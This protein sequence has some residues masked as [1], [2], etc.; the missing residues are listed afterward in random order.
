M[1][2]DLFYGFFLVWHIFGFFFF[3]VKC[4]ILFV[5][6]R[7]KTSFTCQQCNYETPRW[8]GK[9]PECDTW[10]S[11]IE[12]VVERTS[13]VSSSVKNIQSVG[14]VSLDSV[15]R[16][17][18]N[19][20]TTNISELDRVLGGGIVAG[21]VILVAGEPGI[22][23]STI[24]MQ[25][26]E[27]L[28]DLK[29]KKSVL[30]VSGEESTHQIKLRADRLKVKQKFIE[31]LEEVD[32]DKIIQ[33]VRSRR[34]SK[35]GSSSPNISTLIIDS[36]QTMRTPDLSGMAGSAGQIR[37][38]S[39]R[40]VRLAK[41]LSI[42]VIIVGHV[43][44]Q[45]SVAGPALLM[46]LVDTVLWF[47]GSKDLTY[48]MLRAR[49]NRF[50][51]TDEVGIFTMEEKGLVSVD[52]TSKLFLSDHKR[53]VAGSCIASI[54]EG[55]RPILL[56]I[57]ALVVPTKMAFAKR[58]A[59]GFDAKRVELLL[60]VLQRRCGLPLGEYDV[61]VN[62]VGG[63]RI[64]EPGCDLAICL[65]VA[66]AF[67]DKA[68]DKKF[69]A[70]GEVGLLG[71]IRSVSAQEKRIKEAR[72]LGYKNIKSSKEFKYLNQAVRKYLK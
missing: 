26:S 52:D 19:R 44:K 51:A 34:D 24:L 49:K 47:E 59:Q 36:I 7:L 45:G 2:L 53:S 68:L 55:T 32:V 72:R 61:Y 14:I 30:Y 9:C 48:R 58:V 37:E 25:L 17:K 54:M 4:G 16:K 63:I 70:I 39:H 13:V 18:R 11:L 22:G 21:Q 67:F 12:S 46:H 20:V 62:A 56:E 60:A 29:S 71:E 38:C 3:F 33:L 64:K 66:S 10:G 40:L 43:T 28:V 57:Q 1:F 42:P 69:L 23:K 35:N 41:S 27:K 31:V 8:M 5:M 6:V 65:S 15:A 50:G